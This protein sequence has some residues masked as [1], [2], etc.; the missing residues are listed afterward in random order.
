MEI[1]FDELLIYGYKFGISM[2]LSA[3][4]NGFVI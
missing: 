1:L 4:I 2:E 3:K